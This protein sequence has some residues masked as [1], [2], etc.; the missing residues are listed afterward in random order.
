AFFEVMKDP[1]R[2]FLVAAQDTLVRAVGTKFDVK[3]SADIVHV[4]VLEGV[5]EVMKP[6]NIVDAIEKADTN[7]IEK[8]VLTAGERV[9]VARNVPLPQARS[10]DQFKPGAWR[11]G[12]LACEDASLAEIVSDLNR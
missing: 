5:V 8:Q 1:A 9:S 3:R 7:N 6:D 4:S 12:R 2:P 10:V 11:E